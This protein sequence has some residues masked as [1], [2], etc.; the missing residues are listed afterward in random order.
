MR[1]VHEPMG[2]SSTSTAPVH[3]LHI[4]QFAQLVDLGLL[5]LA[6]LVNAMQRCPGC[7]GAAA[8]HKN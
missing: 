1:V 2:A 3:D 4:R 8:V 6:A 5:S 7:S